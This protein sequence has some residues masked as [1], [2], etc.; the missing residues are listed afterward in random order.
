MAGGRQWAHGV[1]VPLR[2]RTGR[3]SPR[4]LPVSHLA[5]LCDGL[6]RA[7]WPQNPHSRVGQD[8]RCPF[9]AS[10]YPPTK[11]MAP[12]IAAQGPPVFLTSKNSPP[13]PICAYFRPPCP[14]IIHARCRWAPVAVPL[15]RFL[16]G[17][18]WSGHKNRAKRRFRNDGRGS[19]PRWPYLVPASLPRWSG[20]CAPVV[21]VG[22]AFCIMPPRASVAATVHTE[23]GWASRPTCRRTHR[24]AAK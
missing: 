13:F 12:G 15:G 6:A 23:P 21:V 8:R 11:Q 17:A 24:W 14:P 2:R 18:R 3:N 10:Q 5:A 4:R 7:Y 1:S 19:V 20:Q 22:F 16:E 9:P